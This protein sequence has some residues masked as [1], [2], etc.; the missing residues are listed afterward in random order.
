[1]PYHRSRVFRIEDATTVAE[2]EFER[3]LEIFR[4]EEETAQQYFFSYLSV[5]SLA[6][7]NGDV[8][9]M[10]NTTPLFW[11]TAHHAMLLSTFVALG[12][13]F[14]QN[15][16]HNIDSL[17]SAASKEL[18]AFSMPALAARKRAAGLTKTEAAAYVIGKHE[19][20]A[21]DL[22]HL[23]KKIAS[24]RRIYENR[25]SQIRHK[26]FAHKALSNLAEVNDLLAKTK[27]DEMKA[28]FAFMSAVYST[29]LEAFH[30]G[31]QPSLNVRDFVLPPDARIPSQEMLPGERVYREGYAVLNSPSIFEIGAT[32]Y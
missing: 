20:T 8:L 19:L 28:L 14:D 21:G 10:I 31:V 25:Y 22:R 6:A 18:S 11:I 4:T 12:R 24:W 30:N 9:K 32:V 26:V 2:T 7:T 27:I 15:S 16:R 13:I 23:R 1:M 5:R 17:M 29:L 3:E